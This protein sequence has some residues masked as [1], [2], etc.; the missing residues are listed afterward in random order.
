MPWA[1]FDDHFPDSVGALKAG[2]EACGLHCLAS[3]WCAANLTDGMLPSVVA[4]WLVGL[5]KDSNGDDLVARLIDAE[6]WEREDG[7]DY[8]LTDFLTRNKNRTR[9]MVEADRARKAKAGRR[10]GRVKAQRDR[11]A[12]AAAPEAPDPPEPDDYLH[13][14]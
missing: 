5:C 3:C 10:G 9:E 13:G 11:Q 4:T 8:V 12:R 2:V 1:Q 6:L 14:F 7:G